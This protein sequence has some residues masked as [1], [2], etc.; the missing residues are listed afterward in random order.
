MLSPR[1]ATS[2]RPRASSGRFARL[3]DVCAPPAPCFLSEA[4]EMVRCCIIA[5]SPLSTFHGMRFPAGPGHPAG[6]HGLNSVSVW[7]VEVV[8]L[9]NSPTAQ[10]WVDA[11][12][13]DAAARVFSFGLG[14]GLGTVLQLVPFHCSITVVVIPLMPVTEPTAQMSLPETAATPA[15]RPAEGLGTAAQLV[16]FQCSVRVWAPL[17]VSP[18]AHTSLAETAVAPLSWLSCAPAGLGLGAT[19]QLAPSQCKMRVCGLA[20]EVGSANPTAQTSLAETAVTPLSWSIGPTLGLGTT[21][22]LRPFQCSIRVCRPTPGTWASPTAHTSSAETADTPERNPVCFGCATLAHRLPF[23]C[24]IT[25]GL[26]KLTIPTAQTSPAET[27]ATADSRS[28]PGTGLGVGTTL[29]AMPS[30][31]SASVPGAS[32]CPTAQTSLADTLATPLSCPPEGLE[33][34]VQAWAAATPGVRSTSALTAA[35]AAPNR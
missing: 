10:D 6:G 11:G 31:C 3:R 8:V 22:H 17:P 12:S 9:K 15:S 32:V 24:N 34:T 27:A 13:A 19:V 7:R 18:T 20:K 2:A 33:T 14:L 25:G 1:P 4:G 30:Q 16:P 26:E 28:L 5:Y 23:Q 29:Q 21:L 35:A